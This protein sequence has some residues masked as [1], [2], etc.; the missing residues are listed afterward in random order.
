M[1]VWILLKEFFSFLIFFFLWKLFYRDFFCGFLY[2]I[3]TN[4]LK[5]VLLSV[6]SFFYYLFIFMS[7]F[8]LAKF[9]WTKFFSFECFLA[10]FFWVNSFEKKFSLKNFLSEFLCV[11]DFLLRIFFEFIL[12]DYLS[13]VIWI[14]FGE[15]FILN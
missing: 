9:F 15:D 5:M 1:Y 3:I 2:Q 4:S 8:F 12:C 7:D 13:G 6:I 14:I 11:I 10:I